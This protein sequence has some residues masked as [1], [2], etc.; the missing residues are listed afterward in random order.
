MEKSIYWVILVI[1]MCAGSLSADT[2]YVD[3]SNGND[4]W[5][6]TSPV[7]V[8]GNTGPFKTI[9]QGVQR[10]E[11]DDTV[12]V[13]DGIYYGQDNLELNF[14]EDLMLKSANGPNEC[15]LDFYDISG[16]DFNNDVNTL[17][18]GFSI[19]GINQDEIYLTNQG[20][21]EFKKCIFTYNTLGNDKSLILCDDY[22]FVKLNNCVFKNNLVGENGLIRLTGQVCLEVYDKIRAI[23][24]FALFFV[25][26][27]LMQL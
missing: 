3:D 14:N 2:Y 25:L 27:N 26:M 19:K 24:V 16:W 7:Y 21:V 23:K 5:D 18:S 15:V 12:I 1:L 6:G 11:D 17:I 9:G 4:D 22:A 8:S 13:A 20:R 10:T